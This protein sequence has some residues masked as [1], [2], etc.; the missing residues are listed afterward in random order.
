MIS[1]LPRPFVNC[2][3]RHSWPWSEITDVMDVRWAFPATWSQRF[4][5]FKSCHKKWRFVDQASQEK[6]KIFSLTFIFV[7]PSTQHELEYCSVSSS[8]RRT[9][10]TIKVVLQESVFP[11]MLPETSR[12]EWGYQNRSTDHQVF[13]THTKLLNHVGELKVLTEI[14]RASL[15][16]DRTWRQKK[17]KFGNEVASV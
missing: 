14:V 12:K 17:K 1:Y 4:V 7:N 8:H 15:T 11:K 13:L 16:L 3:A 9:M 2:Y 10:R 5:L 6:L